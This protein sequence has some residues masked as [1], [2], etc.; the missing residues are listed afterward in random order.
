MNLNDSEVM[1]ESMFSEG[2]IEASSPDLADIRIYN[3]C[4][5]RQRA[6]DRVIARIKTASPEISA[7]NSTVVVAGCMAQ[8]NGEALINEGIAHVVLGPYQSAHVGQILK[9]SRTG[10]WLS[11]DQKDYSGQPGPGPANSSYNSFVTITHGCGNFCSYC[12]VPY[13][14]G[15]LISFDSSKIIKYIENLS[16]NGVIEVTL[17]GQ[18]VNQ[19]GQDSG[20]I[21]FYSLLEKTASITGLKRIHFLTS[22]PRDFNFDIVRVI[23]NNP[24]I[25]RCIHLPLQ[26][27]SD[28]ILADMNRG[29]SLRGYMRIIDHL[30]NELSDFSVSTDLIVGYPGETEDD[31]KMTL[32]AVREIGYDDAF[33]YAYSPR[34]GTAA[35]E[36]KDSLSRQ[37]KIT[38]LKELITLQR[39]LSTKKLEARIGSIETVIP[40]RSSKRS[41]SDLIGRTS[42]NHPVILKGNESDIGRPVQVEISHIIGSTLYGKKNES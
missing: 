8:R 1:K 2:Y 17:L 26:S 23:R 39:S 20:D 28:R 22:H 5:V 14:R 4:S 42:L 12:I 34:E 7:R 37:E 36:R 6:E 38:R 18:N 33:M 13:V 30:R 25:S 32:R 11:Q 10:A 15:P 16:E 41:V 29:Y 24:N 9:A 31:F 19:F 21:P 40:E 3:T 27:G 35:A